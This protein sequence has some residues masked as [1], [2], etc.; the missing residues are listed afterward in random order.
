MLTVHHLNNSRSQR[1]LWLLEELGT[2]Y[3]IKKYER[4]QPM[5]FA[6]PELKEVHPLGKSPVITDGKHTIAE[7]GAIVEYIVETER[8]MADLLALLAAHDVFFV[9][10]HCPLDELERRERARG[11]RRPGEAR[12]DYATA[13]VHCTYDLE[14]DGT[15]DAKDNADAVIAAWRVREAPSA[16]QRMLASERQ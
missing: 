7:S 16:F 2:P 4:M 11:D 14:M 12:R 8:W 5:P 3:E 1:I 10:V 9:A 13:H 15:R 6:P